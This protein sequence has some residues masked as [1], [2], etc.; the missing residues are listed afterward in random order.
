M[1]GL[2]CVLFVGEV[3][4]AP[5]SKVIRRTDGT[6]VS[7]QAAMVLEGDPTRVG[8]WVI[9][10]P[11]GDQYGFGNILNNFRARSGLSPLT[12]DANLSAWASQN[13]AAQS[14]QGLGHHVVPGCSQNAGWNYADAASVFMGW[15]NSPGHY[16]TLVRQAYSYGISYGPGPYWTLN[17]K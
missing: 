5:E 8:K 4:S 3:L 9:M 17:V 14:R 7:C 11:Q 13:N 6:V 1:I 16:A 2:L 12:Y 10:Q 15:H